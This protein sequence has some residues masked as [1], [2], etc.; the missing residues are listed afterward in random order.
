MATSVFT[1]QPLPSLDQGQNSRGLAGNLNTPALPSLSTL[2]IGSNNGSGI[3]SMTPA[4]PAA[5]KAAAPSAY[6]VAAGDT[7]SAIAAKNGMSLAS[8]LAVNPQY[9]VNPNLIKPGQIVNF[10]SSTPATPS[11]INLQPNIKTPSG[12]VV[13]PSTGGLVT[14]PA[15]GAAA[16]K[17]F[18]PDPAAIANLADRIR[19]EAAGAST[20][21]NTQHPPATIEAATVGSPATPDLTALQTADETA[22]KAYQDSQNM[23]PEEIANAQAENSLTDNFNT[24][25]TA[26][27]HQPIPLEFITGQQKN[28]AEQK[29]NQMTSL[30]NTAALLQAKRTAATTA[31][32]FALDRADAAITSAKSDAA[33]KATAEAA[34]N[35]PVSVS[36]GGTLVNPSTGKTVFGS[37]SNPVSVAPGSNLVDPK[38]GKIIYSSPVASQTFS[39]LPQVNMTAGNTPSTT[40][41]TTF[42][43]SLGDQNLAT[44]I[45]G[46]A[47]YTI[48]PSSIPT[49][50]Y[51]GV[52][53]LSQA[54]VLTLASQYDPTY[55][56][57][58]YATRQA[59][60]K[61]FTSGSYSQNITALNTAT[62][63]L[64]S[65]A[66]SM[67]ELGNS[68]VV[69]LNWLK[70]SVLPIFGIKSTSGTALNL[71][72]VSGELANV[73]KKSG[74]TDAEIK[75]IG[76]LGV[77]STPTDV[78]S[79][80]SK[81]V[82]LMVGKLQGLNDTY[83]MGMGKSPDNGFMSTS[84]IAALQKLKD[85][86]FDVTIPGQDQGGGGS[87]YSTPGGTQYEQGADGLYYP[88]ASG[89]AG[90][91]VSA[92]SL[93]EA[94]GKYESG[95]NYGTI[96]PVTSSGDKAY[97]KYQ[98]MGNNIPSWTKEVLGKSM[99]PQQFL[100]DKAA[101]DKVAE[102]KLGQYLTKYGTPEDAASAWFSGGPLSTNMGKKD[103][104]GTTVPQY[105]KSVM[106]NLA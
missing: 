57:K 78:K 72:A 43:S 63:H 32:K 58:Q 50:Q 39:N 26:T 80:I 9:K 89:G 90:N 102:A 30:Q 31:S 45:K 91:A 69:P 106:K 19:T 94:V 53:A 97:G 42:L 29:N 13:N 34:A 52:G 2:T 1:T 84:S 28:L 49:K 41:Q 88:K 18:V 59:I 67:K 95:G 71:S 55:D 17:P 46:I 11:T 61:N 23:T 66:A 62:E 51:K 5:P 15:G 73:F 92:K 20:T 105:I 3:P 54:D 35:K 8:L 68:N 101:Q 36:P 81:A 56:S 60:M 37:P 47:N 16:T 14:P 100:N 76:V 40:D 103:V 98:V 99:T 70:N 86:G 44:L 85:A 25:N 7:L 38:T 33:A 96:G 104:L 65:L 82:D 12:A 74:A 4:A 6:T 24:T 79:Y 48:S 64:G 10:G 22:L 77:N 93:S 87:I 75:N 21:D 27:G 83:E